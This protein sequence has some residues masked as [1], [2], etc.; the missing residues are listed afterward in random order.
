MDRTADAL[1]ERFK[2]TAIEAMQVGRRT[3]IRIET[4]G[5]VVG[6]GPCG[7]SGVMAGKILNQPVSVLPC[8]D[9]RDEI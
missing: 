8:I 4:D 9:E 3:W 6:H 7:A 1:R 2:I 5:G